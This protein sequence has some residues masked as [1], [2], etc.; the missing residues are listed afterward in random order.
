M[1][2]EE[3][4][5]ILGLLEAGKISAD[6]A[7]VLLDAVATRRAGHATAAAAPASSPTPRPPAQL[8]R[9]SID[10]V[11][12]GEN[13]AKVNINVP[14]GLARFAARFLPKEARVEL[15]DQNIDLSELLANLGDEVPDGP[16]VDID[17]S[18]ETG[19]KTAKIRIEVV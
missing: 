10:A 15:E 18:D 1:A 19:A 14:L 7:A 9:I 16:L 13:K 12:G 5:R 2:A 4:D 6:Q 8:L 11:E 3:R 17:T